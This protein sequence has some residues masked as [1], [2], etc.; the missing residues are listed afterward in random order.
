MATAATVTAVAA[1]F[2]PD[3]QQSTIKEK[4]QWKKW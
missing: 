1:A 4:R 3:R 2:L